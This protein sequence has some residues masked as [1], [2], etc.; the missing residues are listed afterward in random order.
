MK[1]ISNFELPNTMRALVLAEYNGMPSVQHWPVPVPETGQILVKID[2]SPINPSD[3]SFLK[4]LYSTRKKLPVVAGFEAS[5]QVVATGDD[6]LSRRLLG[7]NV[8]CFAP[9][10][11]DGSWAEYMVTK[12]TMAIPLRKSI[13]L[14]QGSMLM[15]NPLS[16]LAM[17]DIAKK[18]GH[19]AIVNTAAASALG[20]MLGKM[21]RD[22]DIALLN[23]VRR[24]EQVK[25][26]KD[27]GAN[28][29]LDSSTASFKKE[30]AELCTSLQIS[31]AYDAIAGTMPADLLE[32]M[33]LGSEVRVYG[34]LSEDTMALDPRKLIFEKKKICGF[35]LSEW[36]T[37]QHLIKLLFYF[38][39]IQKYLSEKH[40]TTIQQRVPLDGV[41]D[42]LAT[43]LDHMTAGKVIV[44]PGL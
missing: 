12:H 13:D 40:Q 27:Q 44:K 39:K 2:S 11:G 9:M 20:Q 42:G 22:S 23:I 36:L 30:L 16:S 33:P 17:I 6:W 32:A 25:L 34:G 24:P 8:A 37:H 26:L 7:K 38:N 5:G 10:D 28:Y 14:E 18:G 19:K 15:V 31:L 21:C 29:V 35:W 3:N 41:V 43:Y 4:G 1:T